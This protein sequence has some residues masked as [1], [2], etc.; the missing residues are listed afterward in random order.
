MEKVLEALR[1]APALSV[2]N[3]KWKPRVTTDVS[4]V[5]VGVL[6]EQFDPEC[7]QWKLVAYW[8]RK[9]LPAQTRYYTTD[10]E[11]L[12]VVMAVTQT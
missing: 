5:R 2:W 8:S 7:S 12:A 3:S 9:L 11:W 4:L 6:L 10:C 1:Q